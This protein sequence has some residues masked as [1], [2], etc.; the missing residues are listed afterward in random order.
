MAPRKRGRPARR[1]NV[2]VPKPVAERMSI[3]LRELKLLVQSDVETVSSEKL[4]TPLGITSSQVRKDLAYF[5]QFGS[6]GL[7]YN[8]EA[9]ADEIRKIIGLDR[10]WPVALV[11]C[12]NLGRALAMHKGFLATG[13]KIAAVFDNSPRKLGRRLGDFRIN[14]I[15]NL[16]RVAAQKRISLGIIAV[17]ALSAEEVAGRMAEAGITGI[18]NFAPVNLEAPKGVYVLSVDLSVQMQQLVFNLSSR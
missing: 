5:G 12:G 8:V 16:A 9:L 6:P 17:P 3:Y 18:L 7:G 10:E 15:V 2:D 1:R 13:F 11:G 4:G 14:D